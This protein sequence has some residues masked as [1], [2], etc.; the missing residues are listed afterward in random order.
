MTDEPM[1][2]KIAHRLPLTEGNVPAIRKRAAPLGAKE[3]AA[4]STI[5]A[6]RASKRKPGPDR[7]KPVIRSPREVGLS[8]TKDRPTST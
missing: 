8:K 6:Q 1:T 2:H 5:Q 7:A 4:S 3:M